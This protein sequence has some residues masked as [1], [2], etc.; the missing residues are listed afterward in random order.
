MNI[1]QKTF[2]EI[3]GQHV[4]AYTLKNDHGLEVTCLNYGCVITKIITP[5]RDG[6]CENIV[7][8]FENPEDYG[9]NSPYF[10][11]VVGRIAGRRGYQHLRRKIQK[12]FRTL[13]RNTRTSRC[14]SPSEFS[15]SCFRK[16]PTILF[17]NKIYVWTRVREVAQ[18]QRDAE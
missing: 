13:F 18:F 15:F 14:Y 16:E 4:D 12:A 1:V 10:G 7:L 2:G 3:K 8:G 6:N 11:A 9:E 17:F 5:D